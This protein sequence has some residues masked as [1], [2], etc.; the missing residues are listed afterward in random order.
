MGIVRWCLVGTGDIVRK[1][2][3]PALAASPTGELRVVV[4]T[5]DHKARQVCE[6]LGSGRPESDIES[7]LAASDVDAVYIA[8]PVDSHFPLAAASLRAGKHVLIEKPPALDPEQCTELERL[9][10]TM[11][12][13]AGVAYY[14]RFFPTYEEAARILEAGILGDVV[15]IRVMY[16]SWYDPQGKPGSWRVT[17]ER[18]GGGVL[19]DVGCHRI[20]LIVGLLGQPRSVL[21]HVATVT[22]AYDVEDSCAAILEFESGAHADLALHWNSRVWQDRFEIIGT[23]G[24]ILIDPCDGPGIELIRNPSMLGGIGSEHTRVTRSPSKNV[25]LPVIEDFAAALMS[26]HRPRVPIGEA[27]KTSRILA[28][29]ES[30]SRKGLRIPIG[31]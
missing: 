31:S 30:S 27:G 23:D 10:G 11:G 13:L 14:R 24:R 26:G 19:W 15:A 22:H 20:D 12:L 8:T 5:S 17:K 18:A 1:R 6:D 25:H 7:A 2:V 21:G 4:G 16:H 29:I 9:A 3:G 28:A